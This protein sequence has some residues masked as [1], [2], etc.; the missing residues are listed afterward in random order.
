MDDVDSITSRYQLFDGDMVLMMSDGVFDALDSKGVCEVIDEADTQNPQ[1]LAD[2]VLE[3][4]LQN[5]ANDDCTVLAL[6][7][8]MT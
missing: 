6:R 7:L 3:K 8:F 4:A 5:G 2:V 1:T